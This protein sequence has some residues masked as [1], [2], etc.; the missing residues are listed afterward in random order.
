MIGADPRTPFGAPMSHWP[1]GRGTPRWSVGWAAD[2]TAGVDRGAA[3]EAGRGCRCGRRCR[4][5]SRGGVGV[6]QVAG[7]PERTGAIAGEV[8]A[9]RT[10]DGRRRGDCSRRCRLRRC[11]GHDGVAEQDALR[12]GNPDDEGRIA[13]AD[14]DPATVL[15]GDVAGDGGIDDGERAGGGA[16]SV[17]AGADAGLR[18]QGDPPETPRCC[19]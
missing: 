5:G 8:V 15:A 7:Q 1:G 4:R 18:Y 11:C 6:G 19:R 16:A 2:R 13:L 3:G 12:E 9:P 14:V 10:E 17:D